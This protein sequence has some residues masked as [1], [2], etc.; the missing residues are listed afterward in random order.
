[1]PLPEWSAFS[2][3]SPF[4]EPDVEIVLGDAQTP[5]DSRSSEVLVTANECHFRV[6]QVG[7]YRVRAG[8]EIIVKP[9]PEAGPREVRLFL[10][11]S[12]WAALCYLRG[13]LPLHASV[14]Q[15]GGHGVAFCGPTGA[16][17]S[18]LAAWLVERG[19][20]LVGDDLSRFEIGVEGLAC[21]YPSAPRL[22]LWRDALEGLGWSSDG[23]ERDHFRTDKFHL[24]APRS[25]TSLH[26]SPVPAEPDGVPASP[27]PLR[28]IYLLEWGECRVTRL[29]GAN[30][31][32][33]FVAAATYRGDLLEPMG[34]AA[35]HW[36]RCAEF[37]R[38]VPVWALGRPRGWAELRAATNELVAH[39]ESLAT[40]FAKEVK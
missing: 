24:L 39:I 20:R 38:R 40:P 11:G 22:K 14:V 5:D 37:V 1:M 10:L 7:W 27:L 36:E 21:V 34:R 2:Q 26:S 19:Y 3:P 25:Q 8:H 32:R 9:E 29:T 31:L 18:T 30:A 4:S 6:P 13:I 17:K 16:G 28:A 23:L 15:V 33:R 35:A 12:A